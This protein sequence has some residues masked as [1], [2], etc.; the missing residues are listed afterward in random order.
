MPS[1]FPGSADVF[2]AFNGL[3]DYLDTFGKEHDQQHTNLGDALEAMQ[4]KIGLTGSAVSSS[5]Q[6]FMDMSKSAIWVKRDYAGDI[7]AALNATIDSPRRVIVEP[8]EYV[9][10]VVNHPVQ[11]ALK[12]LLAKP[13]GTVLVFKKGAVVK[14]ADNQPGLDA[15]IMNREIDDP[16]RG[17]GGYIGATLNGNCLNNG[18]LPPILSATAGTT[19]AAGDYYYRIAA[20]FGAVTAPPSAEAKVTLS[21]SNRT[22]TITFPAT[23][24]GQTGWKIYG[25]VSQ[26]QLQIGSSV[27]LIASTTD[28][29]ATPAGALPP[30]MATGIKNVSGFHIFHERCLVYDW[31][32][33]DG[34]GGET[35]A[36]ATE[37]SAYDIYDDC[38]VQTS[39]TLA[40]GYYTSSCFADNGSTGTTRNRCLAHHST[41]AH[42][43]ADNGCWNNTNNF[44]WSFLNEGI[45][46]N[47]EFTHGGRNNSCL[48]GGWSSYAAPF[49]QPVDG[50][51]SFAVPATLHDGVISG[52]TTLTSA[53]APFLATDVGSPI[54]G[55]GIPIGTKI[56][57]RTSTTVVV[58]SK[59]ST[60]ASS[61]TF[62][63]LRNFGQPLGNKGAGYVKLGSVGWIQNNC[64]AIGN[65]TNSGIY[66]DG[67][68]LYAPFAPAGG[69]IRGGE[70][71]WNGDYGINRNGATFLSVFVD[72][73]PSLE[74]NNLGDFN[75]ALYGAMRISEDGRVTA[76][77]L[78][79][80]GNTTVTDGVTTVDSRTVTSAS[81]AFIAADI[82]KYIQSS[83]LPIG[84]RVVSINS[85][86][87]VEVSKKATASGSA[88]SVTILRAYAMNCYPFPV[89]NYMQ[90]TI[91]SIYLDNS[92]DH[93]AQK[94]VLL[95]PGQKI[96]PYTPT[97]WVWYVAL[98]TATLPYTYQFA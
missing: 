1:G 34:L 32:G 67:Y 53:G 62:S 76:P 78:P 11:P 77:V 20:V 85:G 83:N 26:G 7:Q 36:F 63:V 95:R 25:R 79:P 80:A 29:G 42:G 89:M 19:L 28:S 57:S 52:T 97:S 88:Q 22:T 66:V 91:T 56:Q 17:G 18:T 92:F 49:I 23:R 64:S 4:A 39:G 6:Y 47:D 98:S 9:L 5:I 70:Y 33:T 10:S 45:G 65:L 51:G 2:P 15:A 60:N 48:S 37:T 46:F 74:G 12:I 59:V 68:E 40:A 38:E 94:A 24:T 16:S 55:Q 82:G 75:D 72:L 93:G 41:T 84:T 87:S 43:F 61:V 3:V 14:L 50:G 96:A 69:V 44:C 8:G 13:W 31:Y 81:A 86:T 90:G 58:L 54:I 27:G 35:F 21:G 30:T 71:S 73:M